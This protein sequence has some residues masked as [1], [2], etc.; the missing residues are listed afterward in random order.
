MSKIFKLFLLCI[1]AQLLFV[2]PASADPRMETNKNFCHFILDADD[3][4]NESFVAGCDS[5]ITTVEKTDTSIVETKGEECNYVAHGYAKVTMILPQE[6]VTVPPQTTLTFTSEDTK[7]KCTMVESNGR[8]YKSE[9]W[10]SKVKVKRERKN[11][12]VQVIYELLCQ[13][14][15]R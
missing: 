7:T 13:D 6:V 12:K 5:I 11:G 2:F 3:T 4:D 15:Y 8:A 9:N 14:G 1:L 10:V